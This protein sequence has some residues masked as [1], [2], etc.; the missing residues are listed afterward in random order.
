MP[1]K[2]IPRLDATDH[3]LGESE[4]RRLKTENTEN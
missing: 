4:I 1:E 3:I 2:L